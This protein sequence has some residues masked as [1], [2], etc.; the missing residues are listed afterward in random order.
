MKRLSTLAKAISDKDRK[1]GP[2]Y[3]AVV[4]GGAVTDISIAWLIHELLG[5][6]LIVSAALGFILSMT[7]CYFVHEFWSFERPQSAVSARRFVKFVMGSAATFTTRLAVIWLTSTLVALPG[8]SIMQLL[9]AAG[10]SLVVGFLLN[11]GVVFTDEP[12]EE[13]PKGD[14][15]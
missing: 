9:F 11:R 8:G 14:V 15:G 2:R 13:T 6:P 3:L 1:S 5:V 4:V 12:S 10:V 7:I